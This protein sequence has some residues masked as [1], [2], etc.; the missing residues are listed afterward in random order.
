MSSRR[1]I[2]QA[3][4]CIA[5]VSAA[6]PAAA[7]GGSLL[8]GYGGPGQ[9]SQVILGSALVNGPPNGGGGSRGGGSQHSAGS[10]GQDSSSGS[11]ESSTGA[12]AASGVA[13][14]VVI[15]SGGGGNKPTGGAS[16]RHAARAGGHGSQAAR[17]VSGSSS[18]GSRPYP[19]SAREAA[20]RQAAEGSEP[21]GVSGSDLLYILLALGALILTGFI[22]QRMAQTSA[23]RGAGG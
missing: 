8:S 17:R 10:A 3:I 1:T 7:H 9:G 11:G 5:A 13:A 4:L 2:T 14:G 22:T 23:A 12:K 18:G 19:V 20:V 21:L 16:H 15:R 6:M